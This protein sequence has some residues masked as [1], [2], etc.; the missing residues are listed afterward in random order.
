MNRKTTLLFYCYRSY[1]IIM[2]NIEGCRFIKGGNDKHEFKEGVQKRHGFF[3]GIIDD[4]DAEWAW[5]RNCVCRGNNKCTSW[6]W[7]HCVR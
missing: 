3:D 4:F 7:L 6:S 5:N 1:I 2:N